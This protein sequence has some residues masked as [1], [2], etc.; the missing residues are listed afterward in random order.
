VRRRA[1]KG[2]REVQSSGPRLLDLGQAWSVVEAVAVPYC[3]RAITRVWWRKRCA[4]VAKA[5]LGLRDLRAR[6][7]SVEA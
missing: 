6:D 4:P 5:G 2:S 7:A 3:Y 1:S